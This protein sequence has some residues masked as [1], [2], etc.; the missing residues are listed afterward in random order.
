[1]GMPN[2]TPRG[3]DAFSPPNSLR[4][5]ED[6]D[7]VIR[8]SDDDEEEYSKCDKYGE[9]SNPRLSGGGYS[10]GD[11]FDKDSFARQLK[12]QVSQESDTSIDSKKSRGQHH[13]I[14]EMIRHLGQKVGSW[15]RSSCSES[16]ESIPASPVD[17]SGDF[18][19]RSR[20]LGA[21]LDDCGA[22]Y[23]IYDQILKE[24]QKN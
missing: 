5:Y 12:K 16:K 9:I 7:E 18:R 17:T 24:G 22:T 1:M 15:R 13:S 3:A 19:S 10:G 8:E 21:P 23:R 20:S 4:F 2:E 14:Q 6:F 11:R